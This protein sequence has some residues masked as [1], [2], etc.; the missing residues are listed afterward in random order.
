MGLKATRGHGNL[1]QLFSFATVLIT[2]ELIGES[3]ATLDGNTVAEWNQRDRF[4]TRLARVRV[5]VRDYTAIRRYTEIDIQQAVENGNSDENMVESIRERIREVEG[6]SRLDA[7]REAHGGC[8]SC[9][10]KE[11]AG[12]LIRDKDL[13]SISTEL[14]T[15]NLAR[16]SGVRPNIFRFH[17]EQA[18]GSLEPCMY[19]AHLGNV[20]PGYGTLLWVYGIF[21]IYISYIFVP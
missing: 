18:L 15:R 3:T 6:N 20:G 19:W 16:T 9:A 10:A 12:Y 14:L 5:R 17:P 21:L 2:W 1:C 8:H 7:K 11:R 4:E 13:Q